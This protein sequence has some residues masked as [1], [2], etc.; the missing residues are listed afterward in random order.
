MNDQSGVK[1][2]K[3]K[4]TKQAGISAGCSQGA[5]HDE[6]LQTKVVAAV[7][8]AVKENGMESEDSIIDDIGQSQRK[9]KRTRSNSSDASSSN[10]DS[11]SSDNDSNAGTCINHLVFMVTSWKY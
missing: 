7:L 2:S 1:Q 11:D 4:K 3:G 6:Q 5:D 10:L 9:N 8:K